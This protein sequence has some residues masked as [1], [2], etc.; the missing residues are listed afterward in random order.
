VSLINDNQMR[1]LGGEA[2]IFEAKYKIPPKMPTEISEFLVERLNR[3]A[4]YE[5]K[6]ALK[7]RAQV[8]LLVNMDPKAGLVNGSRGVITGFHEGDGWPLVKFLNGPPA[9]VKIEPASWASEGEEEENV[10]TCEQIPLRVAYAATTHKMQG[11]SLDSA[12]VDVGPSIFE[13][14][15]AYVALSRVR[16]LGALYVYEIHPKAFRAHPAVKAF[17]AAEAVKEEE[18]LRRLEAERLLEPGG[19]SAAADPAEAT[20]TALEGLLRQFSLPGPE[21]PTVT[22]EGAEEPGAPA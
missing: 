18:R 22:K 1:K 15:Q 21:G 14:G 10:V 13:Y 17:Y 7:E 19:D 3:D 16:S 8:M 11:S 4:P 5:I 12:L 9:P 6:L 20:A 2:T